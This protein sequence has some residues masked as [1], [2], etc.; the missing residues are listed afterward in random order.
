[1]PYLPPRVMNDT[2]L[3]SA[4]SPYKD[5]QVTSRLLI[6][7]WQLFYPTI[8]YRM[9]DLDVEKAENEVAGDLP[10]TTV[11]D[12]W[13]EDIPQ[14]EVL[15]KKWSQPHSQTPEG[16]E[17]DAAEG[18]KYHEAISVN[19]KIERAETR[20]ELGNFGIN[21][22]RDLSFAIP[23]PLLDSLGIIV[24]IGDIFEWDGE[25]YEVVEWTKEY[26]WK[27]TNVY[28]HIIGYAKR[29]EIGS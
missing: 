1:M 25:E 2:M 3:P 8:S 10:H 5:L 28:L 26:Y 23:T 12:L 11:D 17:L 16:D 29:R 14:S 4:Y 19:A 9:L 7:Q 22:E 15:D 21:D 20:H 18:K 13:G 27:N 24:R 6:E